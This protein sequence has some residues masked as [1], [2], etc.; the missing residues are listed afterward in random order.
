ML[1]R[2][3]LV[4][5]NLLTV[6]IHSGGTLFHLRVHSLRFLNLLFPIQFMRTILALVLTLLALNSLAETA[7]CPR[8]RP[9][10]PSD[11]PCVITQSNYYVLASRQQIEPSRVCSREQAQIEELKSI[12]RD[13]EA[14][15]KQRAKPNEQ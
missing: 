11:L 12:I 13:L 6:P 7:H 2:Y 10:K 9:P 14:E 15:L 1:L 8:G 5:S 3:I 4:C